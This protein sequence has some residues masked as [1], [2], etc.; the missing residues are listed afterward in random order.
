MSWLGFSLFGLAVLYVIAHDSAKTDDQRKGVRTNFVFWSAVLG[1]SSLPFLGIVAVVV[2]GVIALL[3]WAIW[4]SATRPARE[5]R[6][7]V[8]AK[9]RARLHWRNRGWSDAEIDAWDA[10]PSS[11]WW[12]VGVRDF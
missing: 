6:H 9:V 10:D 1:L 7:V 3:V 11:N 12:R 5:R 2:V 4:E 8:A